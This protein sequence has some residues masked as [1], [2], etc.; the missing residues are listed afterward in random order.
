M[1][2]K[3]RQTTL[4]IVSDGIKNLLMSE[5]YAAVSNKR[6][7]LWINSCPLTELKEELLAAKEDGVFE[8]Y[9]GLLHRPTPPDT[10]LTWKRNYKV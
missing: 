10:K 4:C 5:F 8:K 1:H 2:A 3:H 6:A 9:A 7:K